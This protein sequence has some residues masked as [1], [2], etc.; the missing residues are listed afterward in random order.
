MQYWICAEVDADAAR[1]SFTDRTS[2][3]FVYIA[4][5]FNSKSGTYKMEL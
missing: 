5:T 2:L 1:T 3:N 4:Q